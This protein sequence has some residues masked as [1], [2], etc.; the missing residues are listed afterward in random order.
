M[1]KKEFLNQIKGL[2]SDERKSRL[3]DL[4]KQIVEYRCK[5]VV[6]QIKD[7]TLERANRKKIA[8]ILTVMKQG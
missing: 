3:E 7:T 6:G 5:K 2:T 1:K 8:Q 4:C